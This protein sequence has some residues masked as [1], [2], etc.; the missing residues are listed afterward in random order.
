[1]H[2]V[3]WPALPSR[4]SNPPAAA[5]A[6]AEDP[7]AMAKAPGLSAQ[8]SG[9]SWMAR[10][11]SQGIGASATSARRAGG[12]RHVFTRTRA[13]GGV[14][15]RLLRAGRTSRRVTQGTTAPHYLFVAR[16]IEGASRGGCGRQ[17]HAR[18]PSPAIAP[19]ALASTPMPVSF[20]RQ[21]TESSSPTGSSSLRRSSSTGTVLSPWSIEGLLLLA[22]SASGPTSEREA[23]PRRRIAFDVFCG[24]G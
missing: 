3:R 14:L 5:S 8:G 24:V 2:A 4:W 18:I 15:G 21:T 16:G 17:L 10:S 20:A 1:M 7:A 23:H 9:S 11:A 6:H 22:T 12:R 19:G 13:P